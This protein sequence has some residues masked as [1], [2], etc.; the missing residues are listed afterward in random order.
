MD[1]PAANNVYGSFS[2]NKSLENLE[3]II[4]REYSD[5]LIKIAVVKSAYDCTQ[6]MTIESEQLEFETRKLDEDNLYSFNGA[7]AG[8]EKIIHNSKKA[9]IFS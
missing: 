5:L 1:L 3:N 8:D 9:W 6:K 4:K 2:S 7:V